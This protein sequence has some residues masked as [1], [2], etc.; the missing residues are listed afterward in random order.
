MS[1]AQQTLPTNN[2]EWGVWGTSQRSG[3]DQQ[4]IWETTSCFFASTYQ[5]DPIQTRDLLDSVFGRHLADDLSFIAG[6]PQCPE[7]II[8]HLEKRMA[9][10]GFKRW[11]D[12]AVD[13]IKKS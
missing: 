7:A 13:A 4:M 9:K 2:A 8:S 12:N 11:F 1:N 10:K 3:Y 5:L 6:G